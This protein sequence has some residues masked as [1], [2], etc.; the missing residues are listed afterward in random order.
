M[1]LICFLALLASTYSLKP[2]TSS[3]LKPLTKFNFQG[4]TAPFGYFDPLKITSGMD[5]DKLKYIREAELQHSR[6]A[7]TSAVVLPIIDLFNKDN[8]IDKLSI[9]EL[10]SSPQIVQIIFF[11]LATFVEY[12]RIKSNYQ[13]PFNGEKTFQLKED[14]E[15]GKYLSLTEPT[16]RLMNVELNNGRLAMIGVLG[17]VAQELVTNK[18]IF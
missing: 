12:S 17:Y 4:D 18:P 15:P 14:V 16:N 8:D 13:D 7:M 6:I 1:I 10:S 9:Y 2:S 3:F 5:E 11:M